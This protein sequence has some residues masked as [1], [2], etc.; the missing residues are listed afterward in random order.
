MSQAAPE[1]A[2]SP[3]A[4]RVADLPQRATKSFDITPSPDE[5]SQI[6][7]ALALDGLRKLRFS[8]E[9]SPLGKTDWRLTGQ[10]GATVVQPCV[11][12]LAPV[13]T[14][15]DTTITRQFLADFTDPDTPDAE[16][17]EDDSVEA[18]GA[19]IDLW[20][21]LVEALSLAVPLYPRAEDS[22]A[23]VDIRVTEP[24]KAPMSDDEAKPFAGLAAL[25]AQLTAREEDE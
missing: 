25:K 14:R 11:A 2:P 4:L 22:E 13:T 17:P 19:Y 23:A 6:Q 9:L 12:T 24:G 20:H 7:D 5:T 15:I 16:M 8:G 18:L 3:Y 21:V 10:L 1:G